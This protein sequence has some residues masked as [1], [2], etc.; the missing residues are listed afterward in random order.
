[1]TLVRLVFLLALLPVIGGRG[2]A[3]A[4]QTDGAAPSVRV[5]LFEE[6]AP[7]AFEI[8]LLDGRRAALFSENANSPLFELD[9]GETLQVRRR[10]DELLVDGPDGRLFAQTLRLA[11]TGNDP[12]SSAA[13]WR[14]AVTDGQ[15]SPEAR[16]YAGALTLASVEGGGAGLRL[17][18]TVALEP[19]VASVVASEYGF[20]DLEG[21]KAQAVATRT[22]V[23]R[24]LRENGTDHV[25]ADH[26]GA[27]VYRGAGRVTP[28]ARRAAEATRGEVA[29]YE[30]API[31]AVYHSASGGH[32]ARNNTVWD[33]NEAPPYLRARPD[34]YTKNT[35]PHQDWRTTLDRSRLLDRLSERY[36]FRVRGFVIAERSEDGRA[37]QIELLRR[38]G[39]NQTIS[40]NDFRL[41]AN[42]QADG[43][44]LRSTL[45]EA[46]RSGDRYVFEGSG[47]GHGVG[48]SQ[49]GARAMAQA[50]KSYREIL[51]F[52]YPGVSLAHLDGDGA[53]GEALADA[54]ALPT[55]QP[56]SAPPSASNAP[57]PKAT[58]ARA[59]NNKK[60]NDASEK[61]SSTSDER[62][63][64]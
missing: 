6:A 10:G 47:Y 21:N 52:Y 7:R 49:Y 62:I 40:G 50:G 20:D 43:R 3:A 31:Q 28:P 32:T 2:G 29:V 27:Q 57:A 30:G 18:N 4:A 16:S 15:R 1:M 51:S 14:V 53:R 45:F 12:A 25:F 8:R 46:E 35:S 36:G 9:G 11:P 60:K 33:A 61:S 55:V 56:A 41:F 13:A 48:M 26:V 58:T 64:W 59:S 44:G 22:Y 37:A 24:T 38:N 63:G 19:Y 34:P 5:H 54:T 23:L 17:V 42:R 39:P